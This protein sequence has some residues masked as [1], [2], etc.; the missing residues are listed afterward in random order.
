MLWYQLTLHNAHRRCVSFRDQYFIPGIL[1]QLN[2]GSVEES[3]FYIMDLGIIGISI[4]YFDREF[5]TLSLTYRSNGLVLSSLH[6]TES[7]LRGQRHKNSH[8]THR[9]WWL[10]IKWNL[11]LPIKVLPWI[12]ADTDSCKGWAL[13]LS[14]LWVEIPEDNAGFLSELLIDLLH[15][16]KLSMYVLYTMLYQFIII[17]LSWYCTIKSEPCYLC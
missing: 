11:G 15:F 1:P 7:G 2:N 14:R 10:F 13:I 17:V 12:M 3:R 4:V 9:P 16:I 8:L 6:L 5:F